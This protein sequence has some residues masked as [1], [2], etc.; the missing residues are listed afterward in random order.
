MLGLVLAVVLSVASAE[1]LADKCGKK[2]QN[3]VPCLAYATGKAATP[4]KEC[5]DSVESIKETDP[6]CLCYVIQQVHGGNN[7][8]V[9]SMGIR[10]D[11]LL[12]LPS[13]CKLTG[14]DINKC[15]KLL[16]LASNSPDAAIFTNS[17]SAA[18][19][20]TKTPASSSPSTVTPATTDSKSDGAMHTP[21][22]AGV[23]LLASAMLI[24]GGLWA[25]CSF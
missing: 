5:C 22:L 15:P 11:A 20:T 18:S 17:S 4:S 23:P 24:L 7:A 2:F 19:T 8:Q 1:N 9:K 10:E 6:A 13:V 3:V 14:A 25:G 12:Q 21:Q 16:N